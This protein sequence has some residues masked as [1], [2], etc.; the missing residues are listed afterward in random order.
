MGVKK[1]FVYF[2]LVIISAAL[3]GFVY[4]MIAG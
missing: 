2:I 4:G 1:A 3:I